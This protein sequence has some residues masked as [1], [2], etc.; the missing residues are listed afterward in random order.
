MIPTGP[1][2]LTEVERAFYD[3]NGDVWVSDE[4]LAQFTSALLDMFVYTK[5]PH[6]SKET[7]AQFTLPT[8]GSAEPSVDIDAVLALRN[9]IGEYT[10]LVLNC[11]GKVST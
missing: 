1:G 10:L 6:W 7:A 11:S 2:L 8:P 3:H 5:S 4:G 9:G